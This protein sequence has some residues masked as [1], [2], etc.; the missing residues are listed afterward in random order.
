MRLL[1]AITATFILISELA[2]VS[3]VYAEDNIITVTESGEQEVT[4]SYTQESTYTITIP[5]LI[6]VDST[7]TAEYTINVSGNLE[8][9]KALRIVP[10]DMIVMDDEHGKSDTPAYV[11]QPKTYFTWYEVDNE[12]GRQA[13]GTINAKYLTA[14]DWSG[15]LYFDISIIDELQPGGYDSNLQFICSWND[16]G[17]DTTIDYSAYV[18]DE[19]EPNYYKNVPTSGYNRLTNNYP[20]VTWLVL[21]DGMTTINDGVFCYCDNLECIILPNT[22][23]IIHENAFRRCENL[24]DVIMPDNIQEIHHKAFSKSRKLADVYIPSTATVIHPE[25]FEEVLHI[26]YIGTDV[27]APFGALSMN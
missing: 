14:G 21:P 12:Q 27:N 3:I 1:K 20:N 19:A 17:I 25:A 22:L 7:K 16:L 5:K 26:T 18:E 4:V 6:V 24:K 11:Y 9:D 13:K 8:A 10:S 23:E 15:Q 2:A